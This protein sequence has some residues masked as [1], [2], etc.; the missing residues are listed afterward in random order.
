MEY[1]KPTNLRVIKNLGGSVEIAWDHISNRDSLSNYLIHGLKISDGLW[2]PIGTDINNNTSVTGDYSAVR[3][4]AIYENG[5][6][7]DFSNILSVVLSCNVSDMGPS[8]NI[9]ISDSGKATKIRTDEYG[10]VRVVGTTVN[11]TGGDASAA[12]QLINIAALNTVIAAITSGNSDVEAIKNALAS[13]GLN[14][15]TINALKSV[16]ISNLPSNYTAP[17][18][19]AAINSLA[20]IAA[21]STEITA[22]IAANT[23]I[24]KTEDLLID[25]DKKQV[26]VTD[27]IPTDFPDSNAHAK[28]EDVKAALTTAQTSLGHLVDDS[29]FSRVSLDQMNSKATDTL[30]KL[31]TAIT[32]LSDSLAKLTSIDSSA[33]NLLAEDQAINTK[34]ASLITG[35]GL[36]LKT[37]DI[38][39][40]ANKHIMSEVSNLPSDYPDSASRSEL[41]LIKNLLTAISQGSNAHIASPLPAG[42]NKIGVVDIDNNPLPEDAATETTLAQIRSQGNVF[43]AWAAKMEEASSSIRTSLNYIRNSLS[44]KLA[45]RAIILDTIIP[46]PEEL[47]ASNSARLLDILSENDNATLLLNMYESYT[48]E[49]YTYSF[50]AK[51]SVNNETSLEGES[52]VHNVC[53]KELS[54]RGYAVCEMNVPIQNVNITVNKGSGFNT[55]PN[56]NA[57]KIR[58]KVYGSMRK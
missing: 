50:S 8:V 16:S 3:V 20:S 49:F 5:N 45:P 57:R 32:R 29:G 39:T 7:S 31:D 26:V 41:I 15:A 17:D 58:V 48:F 13:L 25:T 44:E 46:I 53:I 18:T 34:L 28:L 54:S 4:Q 35:V 9:G 14:A 6:T 40:N 33:S 23:K 27:N 21:K 2:E 47:A 19:V 37:S 22:L 42:P 43:T 24:L 51:I 56:M 10:N 36:L 55:N 38:A 52:F 30:A 12:N 1:N 11:N